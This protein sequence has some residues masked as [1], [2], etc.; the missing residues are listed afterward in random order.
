VHLN[1]DR[2]ESNSTTSNPAH[3]EKKAA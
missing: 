3:Q 2:A 1:P